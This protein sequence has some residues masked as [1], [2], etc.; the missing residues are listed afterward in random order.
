MGL[1]QQD[2]RV[3]AVVVMGVLVA[4]AFGMFRN[5]FPFALKPVLLGMSL[6]NLAGFLG[7][8]VVYWVWIKYI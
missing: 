3:L 6:V 4:N 2:A 5:S 7:A 8:V 1:D